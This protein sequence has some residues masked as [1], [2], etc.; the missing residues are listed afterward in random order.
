MNLRMACGILMSYSTF[1]GV[2]GERTGPSQPGPH[3]RAGVFGFS[4][5]DVA[6]DTRFYLRLHSI[7]EAWF[8]R[9]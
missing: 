4:P 8:F 3:E 7:G 9:S 1:L 6:H 2:R 5:K